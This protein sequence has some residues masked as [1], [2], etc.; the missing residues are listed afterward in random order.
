MAYPS[1]EKLTSI[2]DINLG[3]AE[4]LRKKSSYQPRG[5]QEDAEFE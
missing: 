2:I 5:I 1:P 3:I 4:G